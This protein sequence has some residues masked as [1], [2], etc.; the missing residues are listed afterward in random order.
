M[1]A[2]LLLGSDDAVAGMQGRRR[3]ATQSS[4]AA[5]VGAPGHEGDSGS[6]NGL[7]WKLRARLGGGE[8]EMA[9]RTTPS[10]V[11]ISAAW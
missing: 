11:F 6:S 5:A 4:K 10:P 3:W 9:C 2:R 7:R 8:C 1:E